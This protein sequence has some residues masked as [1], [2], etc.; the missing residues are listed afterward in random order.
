VLVAAFARPADAQT[1]VGGSGSPEVQVNLGALDQL[2]PSDVV[3]GGNKSVRLKRPGAAAPSATPHAAAK[4]HTATKKAAP[5][6]ESPAAPAKKAG[7]IAAASSAEQAAKLA[8][9]ETAPIT[10]PPMPDRPAPP[11]EAAAPA[12]AAKTEAPPPAVEP[13]A[14]APAAKTETPVPAATAK[15]APAPAPTPQTSAV[16]GGLFGRLAAT[17]APP[18]PRTVAPPADSPAQPPPRGRQTAALTS[19]SSGPVSIAFSGSDASLSPAA[20]SQLA[21]IAEQLASGNDRI[22]L[23]GYAS[24]TGDAG[25]G[26][27]RVAL[28]RVLAVRSFLVDRGVPTTRVNV[29]A[30]GSPTDSGP[31]ERVDIAVVGR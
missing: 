13:P 22:T 18:P 2:P 28:S 1:V 16:S 8:K 5:A 17:E 27:R 10:P 30:L 4:K 21:A 7:K 6:H 24:G 12:P 19:L 20:Q 3:G 9:V 14:K 23:N 29:N 25:S 26:A 31:P 15:P 11:A